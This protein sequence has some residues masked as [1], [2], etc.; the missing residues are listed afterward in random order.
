[1]VYGRRRIGKSSLITHF[2]AN[3]KMYRFEGLAPHHGLTKQKQ[4]DEFS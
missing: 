2:G 4:L 1:M 3:F